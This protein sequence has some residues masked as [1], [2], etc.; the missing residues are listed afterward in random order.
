M[1]RTDF[2]QT[3]FYLSDNSK[4][5]TVGSNSKPSSTTA[6]LNIDLNAET[7]EKAIG[8][9]RKAVGEDL[10]VQALDEKGNVSVS[11]PRRTTTAPSTALSLTATATPST[12]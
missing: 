12:A 10:E 8:V 7:R 5:R 4:A 2:S 6:V 1:N 3:D 11:F 9:I